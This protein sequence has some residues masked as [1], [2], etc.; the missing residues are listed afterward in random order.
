MNY[1]EELNRLLAKAWAMRNNEQYYEAKNIVDGANQKCKR[2][3]YNS[4]G[5]IYHIYMQIAFDQSNFDEALKNCKT[6]VIYYHKT[7]N[8]A[9]IAH[10]TRH[11]AD[12]QSQL[13]K[14]DEA[15]RNYRESIE[16]YRK[17]ND[18][19][20]LDLANAL[21]G[22]AILLEKKNEVLEAIKFWEEAKELYKEC[23]IEAGVQEANSKLETLE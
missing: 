1:N 12:I 18:S 21:R 17:K 6:S 10:S 11:L 23:S 22:H 5:R 16:I 14:I 4:L 2:D 7:E 19:S 9:K 20:F 15:E 8:Q 3:D 13:G